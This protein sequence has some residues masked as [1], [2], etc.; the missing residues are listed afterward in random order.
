VVQVVSGDYAPFMGRVVTHL[1]AA[2]K[3]A[4]N[5]EQEVHTPTHKEKQVR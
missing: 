3:H 4:A 2:A 1:Q 5:P